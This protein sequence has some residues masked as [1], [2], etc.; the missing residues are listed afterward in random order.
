MSVQRHPNAVVSSKARIGDDV[1]IGPFT[2]I[3]DDVEIGN[4]TNVGSNVFIGNGTR[5]GKNCAIHHG[6]SVGSDPQDLKYQGE[7]SFLYVGDHTTVR[8]FATLNKGT[9]EGGESRVGSHC[10]LMAYTHVAH[11][12]IVRDNVIMANCATLAGHVVVE[13]N[14]IIGGLTAV[15]QFCTIGEHALIGGVFRVVKDVPPFVLAGQTPLVFEGLNL[16]GLRRRGFSRESIDAIDRAYR[17]IYRSNL[18]VSQA[19]AQLR[20]ESNILPEVEKIL[21]FIGRSKRGI[22]PGRSR[23]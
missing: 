13:E 2:Y 23:K 18:N 4:G 22:I 9:G 17:I 15:H 21:S 7:K 19:V 11:D 20:S 10:L 1:T 6:A 3:H 12:C 5:I 14:A 8:E 16:V